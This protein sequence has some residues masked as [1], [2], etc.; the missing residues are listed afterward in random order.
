MGMKQLR[1]KLRVQRSR[2][3]WGT[4]KPLSEPSLNGSV[5][6]DP[7]LRKFSAQQVKT[8]GSVDRTQVPKD[9]ADYFNYRAHA[10]GI[11]SH[12]SW[13]ESTPDDWLWLYSMFGATKFVSDERAAALQLARLIPE[14]TNPDLYFKV[15]QTRL[16]TVR[17]Y[18]TPRKDCWWFMELSGREVKT[19]YTFGSKD[20]ALLAFR[21]NEIRWK[22]ISQFSL[23]P[24]PS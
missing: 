4:F 9:Y 10:K 8:H 17:L 20:R 12:P 14:K 1:T 3:R 15:C 16:V 6:I 7:A 18:F 5:Y 13:A 22:V 23:S 19:S 11:G 21:T 24:P 2:R